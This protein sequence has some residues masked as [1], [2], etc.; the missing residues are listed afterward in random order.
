ME[1]GL[2]RTIAEAVTLRAIAG[3]HDVMKYHA[4]ALAAFF[5]LPLSPGMARAEECQASA[6][7]SFSVQMEL[8]PASGCL[9]LTNVSV[10][11][12]ASCSGAMR[13]GVVVGCSESRRL[14]VSDTGRLVT[15]QADRA[16]RREWEIVRVFEYDSEAAPRRAIVIHSVR[17]SELPGLPEDTR[18]VRLVLDRRV[19]RVL[20]ASPLEWSVASIATLGR[21][22]AR[23]RRWGR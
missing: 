22:S 14:V 13:W 7:G 16:S 6:G 4:L 1:V 20:L 8:S 15:L 2:A 21:V 11:E 9:C 17:L 18:R 5:I 10:F 23:R 3:T 12:G 19:L